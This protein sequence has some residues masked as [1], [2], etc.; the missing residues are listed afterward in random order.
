MKTECCKEI[1]SGFELGTTSPTCN[2]PFRSVIKEPKQDCKRELEDK[3]E[4]SHI[5]YRMHQKL[6]E[7]MEEW[8]RG[9]DTKSK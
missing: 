5:G 7:E 1:V 9:D 6:N 4:I 8:M 3:D 2:K